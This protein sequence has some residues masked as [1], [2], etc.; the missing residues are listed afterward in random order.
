MRLSLNG[1][2]RVQKWPFSTDEVALAAPATDDA[3]WESMAQPGKVFYADPEAHSR[4]IPNWDRV[5]LAHIDPED[6]AV[7]RRRVTIP[8]DWQG[9]RIVLRFDAVYP[10][11]RFY[12]NGHCLGEHMSG[13]TPVEFDVTDRVNAG[14]E[15]VVAVRLI[16]RH[17]FV[18][19]DMVRHS[20]EFGG[21]AQPAELF[22]VEPCHIVE[23]HLITALAGDL[24]TGTVSGAVTV[25]NTG[26]DATSAALSVEL[27]DSAGNV[28]AEAAAEATVE[29]AAEAS[30][31]LSLTVANPQLW[32]DEYPDLYTV[33]ILLTAGEQPAQRMSYRTGF[34][35]FD[36]T[37]EGPRLNGNPVKFR[38]VNHLT[39]H[40]EHG[41]YTPKEWLRQNL[42][43]MKR[44]NVN[45]IRTHY[46][47]PRC[48]SDLCDEMGIY[49]LQE[50][51]IDWGTDYI[52]DPEWMPPAW[53]RIEG[54]VRRDRHHPS[55]MAW[56]VGNE[57]MP[58]T[59]EVAEAG[60][61]H[62]REF[63]ALVKRIDPSRPTIFPPPGPANKITGNF[64]LQLGDIA[65]THY[66]FDN[67]KRFLADG[68][69]ENANSWEADMVVHTREAALEQGW[70]G[71]WVS[72]EYGIFNAMPDLLHSPH[73]SIID[74]IPEEIPSD[75]SSFVAFEERM[76]REWGFMRG[77]PTCLGGAFFP[78][79]SCGAGSAEAGNPWGWVRWGEDCDW[80]VITADLLPKPF[81]WIMRVLLSPVWF[82]E[83]LTWNPGDTELSFTVEN[84]YNAIDLAACTLRVQQGAGGDWMT[85]LRSFE[86]IQVNCAPGARAEVRV[87]LQ[88][89]LLE[90]LEKGNFGLCRFTLLDPTGYRPIAAEALVMPA[91]GEAGVNDTA[92]TIGPDAVLAP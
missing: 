32:N 14:E 91:E 17:K 1:E 90:C 53:L 40:P 35:Y 4:D 66:V 26:A 51:A 80:G 60:W 55:L 20:L 62:L 9:K 28:V 8:A 71:C 22:A 10:A 84:Q 45:M 64:E 68:K 58:N 73:A 48:L 27:V 43:M 63:D 16:R 85:C 21:P 7:L 36:L 70:S 42:T 89:H 2:W 29:A 54:A 13:V 50:L 19:M 38:G 59:R 5:T 46:T 23:D 92:M 39:F 25:V 41:M 56:S 52:H 11:G 77:E 37:P 33:R 3:D 31:P 87:P 75:K 57:N 81:F 65:D 79:L 72:T 18:Q 47:G 49:L 61:N 83:R 74:D 76:R 15:A 6:G 69:I 67:V 44:C 34:R 82:P 12:L 88:P 30:L 78:W 86:D 24:V